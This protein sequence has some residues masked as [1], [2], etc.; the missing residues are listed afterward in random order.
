[1][2]YTCPFHSCDGDVAYFLGALVET[3]HS[4]ICVNEQKAESDFFYKY[5]NKKRFFIKDFLKLSAKHKL[6]QWRKGRHFLS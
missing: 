6:N 4:T 3:A 5:D 1:V 2:I